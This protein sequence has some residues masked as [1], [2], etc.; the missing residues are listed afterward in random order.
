MLWEALAI[1]FGGGVENIDAGMEIVN[2]LRRDWINAYVE[3]ME[4]A[5]VPRRGR[6]IGALRQ[7]VEEPVAA[8]ASA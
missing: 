8:E 7:W 6:L 5:G 4:W 2:R 3:R 1:I